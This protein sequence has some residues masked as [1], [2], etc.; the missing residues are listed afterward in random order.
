[1]SF[2]RTTAMPLFERDPNK[3]VIPPVDPALN[4]S[5]PPSFRSRAG[6]AWPEEGDDDDVEG[7]KQQTRSLKQD[8]VQ[9]SRNALRLAREAEETARNTLLRLGDQSG[10]LL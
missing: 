7:I 2:N 6:D 4:A 5:T 1:M 9:S 10:V 3:S 8:S